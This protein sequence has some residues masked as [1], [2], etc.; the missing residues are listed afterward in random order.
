MTLHIARAPTAVARLYAGHRRG[1]G[2]SAAG[3]VI[4]SV[5]R[6]F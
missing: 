3:K 1:R 5:K 6:I 2:P 4:A